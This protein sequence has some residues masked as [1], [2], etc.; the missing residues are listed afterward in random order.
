MEQ[1]QAYALI[2]SSLLK[3][4]VSTPG[5]QATT[6]MPLALP[7]RGT[8]ALRTAVVNSV[9]GSA[10]CLRCCPIGDSGVLRVG[11]LLVVNRRCNCPRASFEEEAI[12]AP[13]A[14]NGLATE[15]NDDSSRGDMRPLRSPMPEE[16]AILVEI[17]C[18]LV[19]SAHI[20]RRLW[21]GVGGQGTQKGACRRRIHPSERD[22]GSGA[23]QRRKRTHSKWYTG[24][25]P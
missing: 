19:V 11:I 9:G 20:L 4:I 21:C 10:A 14:R 8:T 5:V 18:G 23:C 7:V 13:T 6:S 16:K 25:R 12:W 2:R 22:D 24:A 1:I 15:A 17:H 3:Q